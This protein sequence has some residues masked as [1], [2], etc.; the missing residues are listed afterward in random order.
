MEKRLRSSLQSSAEEFLSSAAKLN[1]KS[2]K[3]TLKTLIHAISTSSALFSALP[4]SLHRSISDYIISYR[5]LLKKPHAAPE[6]PAK[7][8]P[9]KRLRRSSRKS[10]PN[11]PKKEP[12][13]TGGKQETVEKLQILIQIAFLCLSHPKKVFSSSDLL[14][15]VQMLHDN[16]LLFESDTSLLLEIASL[17]EVYWKENFPG[18]EMLISQSLPFLVSRSLTSKKK[19]D[20]H[21]V[22]A[23]REALTLF[24]FEDESIEDLKSLLIRCVIAPLF[25]KTEDG[26][27]F[28]AFMFGLSLQLLKEALAMIKSQ[29]PFGR[30]SIL[31]AYGEILFRAWK[32]LQGEF[33]DEIENGFLQVL[34]DS[35]IHANSRA[36][37]ASIRRVLG[38]F[39]TQRVTDGVE[40]F[41]FRL[42]EPVIFRSL[43]VANSSVRLNALHLLLDLFPLEDPDATKEVKDTLL[44]KQFFLLEKLLMDE[45]PDVRVVAVEGCC[46]VLHLFWEIIPPATITKILTKIFDD[47][48]HDICHE[49]RLSTLNGLV[50]LLGNPQSYEILKVL[51]PR[52]G[53][54][55]LDTVLSIRVAVLDLLLLIRDIR[56]FQFNKVVG[57][58][59]LLSN[60]AND[61]SQVAQKITRL[62]MPSYFP[63]KVSTEEASNRC[64]TLIKRSPMAGARFCEYAALEGASLESFME[65]IRAL[66]DLVLSHD[67]LDANQ[68]EGLLASVNHLCNSL[69]H[70]P[71]YKNALKDLFAGGKAK[72]IFAAASTGCAQSSVLNIFSLISPEDVSALVEKCMHLITDCGGISS[73]VKL[74]DEVRSAQ[75]FLLSLDGFD[76]MFEALTNLLQKIA[77]R[78]HIKFGIEIPKKIISPGKRKKCKSSVKSSAKWKH[79]KG[80]TASNFEDDYSIALGIAWQIKDMLV[81]EDFRKA[82]LQSQALE[83]PFL[84]L[85]VISETSILQGVSCENVDATPVLAYTTLAL[86]MTLQKV[87]L[88]MNEFGHTENDRT[89]RSSTLETLLDKTTDHLLNCTEKMLAA[90]GI[91]SRHDKEK[92]MSNTVKMLTAILK[93]IV[94]S[95][96]M[97]FLNHIHRRCLTFA[98]LYVK[99]VISILAQQSSRRM[100]FKEDD[101]KESI[102]CM[103][104]S[105][106]YAAKLLNL[107]LKDTNEDSPSPPEAFDLAN[108]MLDLIVSVELYLGSSLAARLAAAAKPW[109]PDLILAL[110]SGCILKHASVEN[111]YSTTL[112]HLKRHFPS[113]PLILAK[114]ELSEVRKVSSDEED[115]TVLEA[116]EFLV[117]KGFIELM[118]SLLKG[119]RN[120]LDA[121]GVMFLTHSVVGLERKDFG[122][123]LGIIHFVCVKLVEADDK[124]WNELDLM[125][126]SLPDIYP[127]IEREIEEE[128]NEV[129]RQKLHSARVLL[130][131]VWLYHVYE[132]GRFTVMEEEINL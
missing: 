60:L 114:I 57:L 21:R 14:P 75:K 25:L 113:W 103:K 13:L 70:E 73:N 107:V 132:T 94:D 80:K 44:D 29:I 93:F 58:D 26:R 79:I 83:I 17:C 122:L 64:I 9:S 66:M 101:L 106:S 81:S 40:K 42:A 37:A 56:T 41:L 27:R 54:L 120:V 85:K 129:E 69:V 96:A 32:G 43:Q 90:G 100:R 116:E 22:Y 30:K 50:Y 110:G 23:L 74:Q 123:V 45:C 52:L 48:S 117:F 61:Q 109:L 28:L 19:V 77:Y 111:T 97:G 39:I 3:S 51:L 89:D 98:S 91:G 35:A 125:L 86:H 55:M 130:E 18:R 128:N 108:D 84:A 131:P 67:K 5:D 118:L 11:S 20:V 102:Q 119:C 104:S 4:T 92:I 24:D 10:N 78:C 53:H 71:S 8:P 16:L 105:F 36:F 99:H 38:G 12:N 127:Q 1:L 87:N 59:V 95:V 47:M 68:I 63:S 62:L 112:S 76:D 33:K 126:S 124:E 31:E 2:S 46:R 49:V 82:I 15:A 72:R 88:S 65:L 34:I 115:D 6:D 7:S 121:V